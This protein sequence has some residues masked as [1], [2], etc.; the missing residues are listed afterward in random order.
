V[1]LLQSNLAVFQ[2]PIVFNNSLCIGIMGMDTNDRGDVGIAGVFGGVAG[3]G[4]SAA[5]SAVW[6][7]DQFNPGPGGFSFTTTASGTHNRTDQRYGD[8]FTVSR[9]SP[10]GLAFS[11]TGYALSGGTAVSN[12]NS[13]YIE[14]Y[15][16]R[17]GKCYTGWRDALR[18][19]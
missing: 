15:R 14:F 3:G 4:G 13:R 6:M 16:N 1:V 12:V 10:C 17:D 9:Q 18:T 19:P 7:Q 11:A 5:N 8:Y 2:Q